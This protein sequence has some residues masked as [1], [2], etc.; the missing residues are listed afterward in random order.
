MLAP[1][2]PTFVFSNPFFT[3]S[4][5]VFNYSQPLPPPPEDPVNDPGSLDTADAAIETFDRAREA[6]ASG[7]PQGALGLVDSAIKKLPTDAT[8]HEF[9][10]LCLFALKD[11]RRAAETL[12]AVLAAGPGWDWETM[13]SLYADV[14]TYTDQL[15][16]LEAYQRANPNSPEASFVLAYHYLVLGH[17]DA[18]IKQVENVA[19]LLPESQVLL[20]PSQRLWVYFYAKAGCSGDVQE[21]FRIEAKRLHDQLIEVGRGDQKFNVPGDGKGGRKMEISRKPHGRVPA[22]GHK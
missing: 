16:A 15:R 3:Q 4:T 14:A 17:L 13:H 5:V 6:F 1:G 2:S 10:A 19:K 11:Y 22:M 18:A 20:K 12:Y 7:D 9:R 8:L 21:A